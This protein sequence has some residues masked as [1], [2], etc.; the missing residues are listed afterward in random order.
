MNNN[1]VIVNNILFLFLLQLPQNVVL[2]MYDKCTPKS[3]VNLFTVTANR[4]IL[5]RWRTTAVRP[6]VKL[7]PRNVHVEVE[8]ITIWRC[9]LLQ[10]TCLR[11]L[12]TNV[13]SMETST[14]RMLLSPLLMWLCLRVWTVPLVYK[15]R[16]IQ[17]LTR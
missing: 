5:A 15:K 10:S 6:L 11:D 8:S 14:N 17:F 13:T 7:Y 9:G 1:K 3:D 4:T 2:L 16:P 12:K